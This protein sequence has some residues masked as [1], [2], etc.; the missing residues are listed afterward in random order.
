MSLTTRAAL[1]LKLETFRPR[2]ET[3]RL[4]RGSGAL[5]AALVTAA[6]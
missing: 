4:K 1:S 3:W 5:P 6:A 2:G